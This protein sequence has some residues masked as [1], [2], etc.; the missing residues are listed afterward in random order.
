MLWPPL[1]PPMPLN[2][3][4]IRNA[5]PTDKIQR[6]YDERGLYLELSPKGGMWWRFKYRFNNSTR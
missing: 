3:T 2:A 6:L 1:L 5:K 4:Q